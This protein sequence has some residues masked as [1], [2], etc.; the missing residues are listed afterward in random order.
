[1]AYFDIKQYA[2]RVCHIQPLEPRPLK[3][4]KRCLVN[5]WLIYVEAGLVNFASII[6]AI[7]KHYVS[8]HSPTS[9]LYRDLSG[10]KKTYNGVQLIV[11]GTSNG[12]NLEY[13]HRTRSS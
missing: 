13:V 10:L 6:K 2:W 8:F 9:N 5:C 3:K 11:T 4:L 12:C 1:M 7:Y